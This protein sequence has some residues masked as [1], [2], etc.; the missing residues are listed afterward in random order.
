MAQYP[1][2]QFIESE[3]KIIPFLTFRQFFILVGG[4]A[5]CTLIYFSVSLVPFILC[6]VPIMALAAAIAF[7]KVNGTPITTFV[8]NAL[9][10]FTGAKTYTWDKKGANGQVK[11]QQNY[12]I[13]NTEDAPV[14]KFQSSKLKEIK[15]IV[16]TK[17][18]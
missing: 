9:G 2:P 15:K 10:F 16:E 6:S 4:A 5:A 18:K 12:E 14:T 17:L 1:I 13:K 8:M 3:S 11:I 7:L